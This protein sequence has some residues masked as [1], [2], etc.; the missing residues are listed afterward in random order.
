M[1]AVMKA[2]RIINIS[3]ALFKG[4]MRSRSGV[5]F[6][7]MFPVMLLLIFGVIFQGGGEYDLYIINMDKKNGINEPTNLSKAFIDAL[8]STSAINVI[9]VNGTP[10]DFIQ[11]NSFGRIRLLVIPPRFEENF[12]K[13]IAIERM[14]SMFSTV[15]YIIGNYSARIPE[16]ALK[17]MEKG[18]VWLERT[19]RPEIRLVYYAEKDDAVAP[20]IAGVLHAFTAS[21]TLKGVGAE[22]I[23]Q[24]EMVNYRGLKPADYYMPGYISAF[25][26][27]NGVIGLTSTVSDMRRRGIFKR[28]ATTPLE[29]R[30]WVAAN[31]IHQSLLAIMLT[32]VMLI[33]ARLAFSVEAFPNPFSWLLI[34]EGAVLF[35]GI[36]MILGSLF[37][38][39]EA[40]TAIANAIAFP[41]MFLSGT[42]WSLEMMPEYLQT[43]AKL[44][45]LT[46]FSEGLRTAMITGGDASFNAII[47]GVLAVV[48]LA[49]GS[50]AVKWYE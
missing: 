7:F 48:F 21:F 4:W 25:I 29:K 40:A 2:V 17:E 12:T 49:L 50:Y 45:P 43:I 6:S 16:D 46:Y 28:L 37:R 44:I 36:G 27:T 32:F 35:S 41:M 47:L 15:E 23:F 8:N 1:K 38:D 34:F 26:M 18:R 9:V 22:N 20:I 39:V 10:Q 13:A 19:E 33:V 42:F 3:L 5:F 31:V 11:E 24:M 14:K 30:E